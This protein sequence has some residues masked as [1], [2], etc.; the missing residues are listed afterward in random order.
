MTLVIV[1]ARAAF[2]ELR[3]TPAAVVPMMVFPALFFGMFVVPAVSDDPVAAT[4]SAASV[5]VFAV[6]GVAMFQF[7]VGVAE[8]RAKPWEGYVRTLPVTGLT[9]FAGRLLMTVA[10]SAL[11]VAPAV[12]VA[13]IFTEASVPLVRLPLVGLALIGGAAPLVAL[14]IAIG[15]SVPFK[16]AIPVANLVYLPMAFAA[17]LFL[18]PE[19]LPGWVQGFSPWMPLR[20][21]AELVWAAA[22]GEPVPWDD[23]LRW[24]AWLLLLATLALWA[25]R[26]D[27]GARWR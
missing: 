12:V 24:V 18:P 6:A 23:L 19:M 5:L 2:D 21:W 14:G 15:Y 1:H 25:Y 11:A 27:E 4:F 20:A 17:G 7:G 9:R 16:A 8:E 10:F 26:R 3:R 13:A 22:L